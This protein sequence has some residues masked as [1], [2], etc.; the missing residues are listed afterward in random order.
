MYSMSGAVKRT[1]A[2]DATRRQEQA[3]ATRASVLAVASRRFLDD[4]YAATTMAAIAGEAGVSVETVYKAFGNKPGILKAM[5]D[6]AIAGDDEPVALQERTMIAEI[7]AE[8]D[9]RAK[10]AIYGAAYA[11]RA[12]RAVPVQLLA[13]DAAATDA[14]A[15]EVWRQTKD[16]RLTGMTMFATHLKQSG[17]LRKG[18]TLDEA[19]DVLWTMT[20]PHLYELL[21]LER[22]W[23]VARFGRWVTQQLQAALVG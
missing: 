8:P 15:S 18:V 17:S 5:F 20:S 21:V 6:V 16:E 9:P 1:R 10:L 13:R 23:T 3:R 7:E 11:E 14:G 19:R 4:G 2:Y 22:G 12:E